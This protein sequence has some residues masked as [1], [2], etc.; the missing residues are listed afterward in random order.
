MR[1][2]AGAAYAL[3]D[4]DQ[5]K[6]NEDGAHGH[7]HFAH[8]IDQYRIGRRRWVYGNDRPLLLWEQD[9]FGPVCLFCRV[10]HAG[11]FKGQRGWLSLQRTPN[12]FSSEF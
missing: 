3:F 7:L 6:S 1:D 10:L 11:A 8:N 4:L 2:R 9:C 12:K 5:K